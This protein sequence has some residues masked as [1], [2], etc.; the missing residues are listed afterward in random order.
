M[1]RE[2]DPRLRPCLA[3]QERAFELCQ[4]LVQQLAFRAE[5]NDFLLR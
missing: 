1:L 4:P 2:V 5:Q 3:V